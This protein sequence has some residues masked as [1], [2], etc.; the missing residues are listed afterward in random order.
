MHKPKSAVFGA[1]LLVERICKLLFVMILR[2]DQ[3]GSQPLGDLQERK[4]IQTLRHLHQT[5]HRQL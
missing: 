2:I 4:L 1:F 3:V 5:V